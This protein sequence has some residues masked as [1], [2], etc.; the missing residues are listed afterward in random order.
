MLSL[1]KRNNVK[2]RGINSCLMS[3]TR[4]EETRVEPGPPYSCLSQQGLDSAILNSRL[5]QNHECFKM[6]RFPHKECSFGEIEVI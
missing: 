6:Y 5:G 2:I 3:Q 1:L 4:K